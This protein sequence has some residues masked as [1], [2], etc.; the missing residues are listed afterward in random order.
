[1]PK[2]M[3]Y[4]RGAIGMG[5]VWGV[6][7]ALAG[8]IPRWVLGLESDLPFPI[9]FGGLGFLAGVIFSGLL[10]LTARRRTFEQMSLPRFVISGAAGGLLL[11]ALFVNGAGYA[12]GAVLAIC[13]TFAFASA[14][15]A[16]G[17]LLLARRAT[18]RELPAGPDAGEKLIR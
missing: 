5:L 16:A 7:F 6:A 15:C 1:M 18:Q 8:F 9:L 13:S 12:G 2:W 17:S 14:A 10:I 11:S 3:R 4:V